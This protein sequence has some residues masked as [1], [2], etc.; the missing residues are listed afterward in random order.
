MRDD[1]N[2]KVRRLEKA[3]REANEREMSAID[4]SPFK[5]SA[6]RSK[7][8]GMPD[9]ARSPLPFRGSGGGHALSDGAHSGP[10]FRWDKA[11]ASILIIIA[12]IWLVGLYHNFASSAATGFVHSEADRA[13]AHLTAL[14][15][16][17]ER[18][19]ATC[20]SKL[21]TLANGNSTLS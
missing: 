2:A 4:T 18:A 9:R 14:V 5:P 21:A 3:L 12:C 15:D 16:S 19:L 13:T 10:A 20:R 1:T 7:S 6:V 17:Q 8:M 11:K